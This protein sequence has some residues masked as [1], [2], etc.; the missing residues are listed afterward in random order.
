LT[1]RLCEPE[2]F[3]AFYEEWHK[4]V[5]TVALLAGENIGAIAAE[6]KLNY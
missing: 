5:G 4:S 3:E 1:R 6:L 2:V